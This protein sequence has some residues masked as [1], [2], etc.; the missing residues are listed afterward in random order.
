MWAIL[1]VVLAQGVG[2]CSDRVLPSTGPTPMPPGPTPIPIPIPATMAVTGV[3]PRT[4]PIGSI[5]QVSGTGFSSGATVTFGAVAALAHD[6]HNSTTLR[7]VIPLNGEGTVDVVVTNPNGDS[8]VLANGFTYGVVTLTASPT[9]VA[10]GAGISVTWA[11]PSGRPVD[12]WVGFFPVGD[13]STAFELGWTYTN[14]APTGS[15]SRSVPTQTGQ[16]EFRYLLDDGY[17]DVARAAVTVR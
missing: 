15:W 4:A 16:Y 10:P 12:D 1:L 3:A 17:F 2:G 11:A 7:T 8:A 13:P 9:V 14:G 6:F 5:V